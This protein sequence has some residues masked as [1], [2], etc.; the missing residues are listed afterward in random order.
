MEREREIQ[1]DVDILLMSTKNVISLIIYELPKSLPGR[2]WSDKSVVLT[3]ADD[4]KTGSDA[5]AYTPIGHKWSFGRDFTVVDI[6]GD[7]V[8]SNA[9]V[10]N[11]HLF[12]P[13]SISTRRDRRIGL[14]TTED[15]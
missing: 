4:Q 8:L 10:R 14:T 1:R 11:G 9:P 13:L 6:R 5:G 12:T 15:N 7:D 3:T 2:R